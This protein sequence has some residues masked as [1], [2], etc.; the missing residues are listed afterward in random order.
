MGMETLTAQDTDT[1]AFELMREL[2]VV[3]GEKWVGASRFTSMADRWGIT[4]VQAR[5]VFLTGVKRLIREMPVKV[6]PDL[7]VRQ[8]ILNAAQDALDQA[9][10]LEDELEG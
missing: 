4:D 2:V 8:S 7:D 5:I 1:R 6:F 3:T 9:I 10:D